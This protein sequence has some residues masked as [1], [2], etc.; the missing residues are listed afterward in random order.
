MSTLVISSTCSIA[1]RRLSST[2]Y[3]WK[4]NLSSTLAW[5]FVK[6]HVW[7]WPTIPSVTLIIASRNG[8]MGK[9]YISMTVYIIAGLSHT[10]ILMGTYLWEP[11]ERSFPQ[12]S[13]HMWSISMQQFRPHL[14]LPHVRF[15]L[16]LFSHSTSS[17]RLVNSLQGSSRSIEPQ[18]HRTYNDEIVYSV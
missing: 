9:S 16:H 6:W 3:W 14:C 17:G 8:I 1:L 10:R 18:R 4:G 15:L 7:T 11:H 5:Q 2:L 12:T 13:V